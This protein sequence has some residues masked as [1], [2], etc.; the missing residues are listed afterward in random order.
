MK[1][2]TGCSLGCNKLFKIIV[3]YKEDVIASQMLRIKVIINFFKWQ[4]LFSF[5]HWVSVNQ[6]LVIRISPQW[7]YKTKDPPYRDRVEIGLV[8]AHAAGAYT[9]ILC[10]M[11]DIVKEGGRAPPTLTSL[12]WFSI[13][14]WCTPESGHCHSVC[15]LWSEMS[16]CMY[17]EVDCNVHVVQYTFQ[18]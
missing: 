17:V 4:Q 9:T 8:S 6:I 14:M 10:V 5:S 18:R 11:I 7:F 16:A 3:T 13:M 1:Y 15:T 2:L 12:G